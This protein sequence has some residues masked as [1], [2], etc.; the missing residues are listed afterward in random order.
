MRKKRPG[1]KAIVFSQV[2]F[3]GYNLSTL[4]WFDFSLYQYLHTIVCEYVGF[5]QM[6]VAFRSLFK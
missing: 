1:S 2:S 3:M 5:D 4:L 6:E